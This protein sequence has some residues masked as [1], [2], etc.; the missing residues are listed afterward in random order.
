MM[1]IF[2]NYSVEIHSLLDTISSDNANTEYRN[3]TRDICDDV[4]T[5]SSLNY[6]VLSDMQYKHGK[7]YIKKFRMILNR[8][9]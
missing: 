6:Y 7:Q 1:N 5:K 2:W 8:L 3:I 4:T 9:A